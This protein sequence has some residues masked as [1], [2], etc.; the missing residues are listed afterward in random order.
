MGNEY[1]D[2]QDRRM[3]DLQEYLDEEGL[4]YPGELVSYLNVKRRDLRGER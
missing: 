3:A 2:E 1:R 4:P